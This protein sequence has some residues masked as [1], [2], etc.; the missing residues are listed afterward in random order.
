[1]INKIYVYIRDIIKR[2]LWFVIGL[3]VI[4]ILNVVKVPY[5]VMLPGGTIDLTDRISVDGEEVDLEGSFNM[6]YVTVIQGN[7]PYV[8]VG[9]ILPDWDVE[10]MSIETYDK[11]TVEQENMINRL[12]LQGSKF[13]AKKAAFDAAGIK[14]DMGDEHSYVTS[15]D[16]KA[17]SELKVGDDITEVNGKKVK[18]TTDILD[19]VKDLK[20][21]DKITLKVIRDEKEIE[22]GTEIIDLNGEPKMG[23]SVLTMAEIDT[24]I[25]IEINSK[26]SE[27]GPS[28]GMMMALMIYNAITD[29]DLT[30]GKKV[31][32]TGTIESDG[33][34]GMIGGIKF[35]VMGAAKNKADIFLVPEGNYKEAVE[36]KEKKGYDI[37]IVSVKTL[38]DA[39]KYL[40]GLK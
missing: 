15:I 10:K 34:V 25:D 21:G 29:Q 28:G 27:S 39:I 14:Y 2:N 40:E 30:H 36:I 8:L 24:D 26:D 3:L 23:V 5:E 12:Y 16:A 33:S 37:E 20:V 35:K 7:I 13:S 4:L 1:M 9:S 32:G 31:V 11:E 19:I 6:A 22:V 38:S 18:S 17:K